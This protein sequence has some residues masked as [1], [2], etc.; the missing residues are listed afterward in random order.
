[1]PE[2][3]PFD[4]ILTILADAQRNMNEIR[5]IFAAQAE[6]IERYL[7]EPVIPTLYTFY[8]V[9]CN[10]IFTVPL[11]PNAF[12]T[13]STIQSTTVHIAP[14]NSNTLLASIPIPNPTTAS[15]TS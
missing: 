9:K 7:A 8:C 1:M 14:I 2:K 11:T 6:E 15:S 5:E 12:F 13:T 3:R 10:E 4:E